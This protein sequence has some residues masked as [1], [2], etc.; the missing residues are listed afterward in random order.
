VLYGTGIRG[1]STLSGVAVNIGLAAGT[2]TY[3]GPQGTFVGLDQV[4]VLLPNSLAGSGRLVLTVTV[5]G[6]TT[7]QMQIAAK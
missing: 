7:N 2:V 4:N 6:Q 3:A 5:D 1:R